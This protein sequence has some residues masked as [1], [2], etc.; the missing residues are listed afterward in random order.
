M[1]SQLSR[2]T[3]TVLDLLIVASYFLSPAKGSCWGPC[4]LMSGCVIVMYHMTT[5]CG[6]NLLGQG[7]ARTPRQQVHVSARQE[8]CLVWL[9]KREESQSDPSLKN[10][11][12][13]NR[14]CLR[15]LTL[16]TYIKMMDEK[17]LLCRRGWNTHLETS[18][19]WSGKDLWKRGW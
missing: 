2:I 14:P 18:T 7:C 11:E 15:Q 3:R 16:G 5:P 12:L 17:L 6:W 1:I 8:T 13:G 10:L 9:K 19:S 4:L